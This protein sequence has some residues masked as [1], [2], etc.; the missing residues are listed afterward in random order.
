M[1]HGDLDLVVTDPT[2]DESQRMFL[3]SLAVMIEVPAITPE[4]I[5]QAPRTDL[6]AV[7]TMKRQSRRSRRRLRREVCLAGF[8]LLALVPIVSACTLGWS[9]RPDRI[10]A[11]SIS[12]APRDSS[13][14]DRDGFSQMPP[15]DVEQVAEGQA[16]IASRGAVMV[17]GEPAAVAPVSAVETPVIFPGYVLPDDSREDSLHEGS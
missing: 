11:C 7:R 4:R 8:T 16:M 13:A 15:S 6:R 12:E 1:S 3:H 9:N 2:V 10:V 14:T 17:S 5:K